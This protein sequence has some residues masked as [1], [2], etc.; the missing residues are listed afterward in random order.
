MLS[1]LRKRTVVR[2]AIT[3]VLAIVFFVMLRSSE[4][5]KRPALEEYVGS[6]TSR[7]P[8]GRVRKKKK[9]VVVEE[10][11]DANTLDNKELLPG[12]P[13]DVT[14][15]LI[16]SKLP[17]VFQYT[18]LRFVSHAWRHAI[19]GRQIY[20]ARV[21]SSST[22]TFVVINHT[23]SEDT[24]AISLYSVREECEYRLPPIPG[25]K[26][27]IPRS[28]NC[29][30][31]DGKIYI[32]G[33][34][35]NPNQRSRLRV[36]SGDVF[37][38]DVAAREPW[39]QCASMRIPRERF[40]CS[41]FGGKIY[42]FGGSS[43]NSPVLGSEVYDPKADAWAEISPMINWRFG[44][45]VGIM[46][47][48]LLVYGGI[49]Y[50]S[51]LNQDAHSLS[52]RDEFC[53]HSRYAVYRY[54]VEAYSPRRD[55]WRSVSGTEDWMRAL[56]N[57]FTDRLF[58]AHGKLYV[59][60]RDGI[61]LFD[62]ENKCLEQVQSSTYS[63]RMDKFFI[64]GPITGRQPQEVLVADDW[65]LIICDLTY[66]WHLFVGITCSILKSTGFGLED[67]KIVWSKVNHQYSFDGISFAFVRLL[68][69]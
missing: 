51:N 45:K 15:E 38:L 10:H 17:W 44:H 14:L 32:L 1:Q 26:C 25:V 7:E 5:T 68:R 34:L 11:Q 19:R 53:S 35:K 46:G 60:N 2:C 67:E 61:S 69:L 64:T 58:M 23:R 13:D 63:H 52:F 39:K 57:L 20:D 4:P 65:I 36:C 3:I 21:R 6:T 43:G 22:Q 8:G 30:T 49:H 37:V 55:S 42:V 41:D 12:I 66:H 47:E 31:M 16:T 50:E 40:G 54:G 9:E 18:H 27:G 24:N 28:C 59:M 48:E 56:L 29:V 33:G 62:F